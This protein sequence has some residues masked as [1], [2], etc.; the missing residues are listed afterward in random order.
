MVWGIQYKYTAD[1]VLLVLASDYYDPSDYIRD[2]SKSLAL[3][4]TQA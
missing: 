4:R 1:A 3:S 2:Y